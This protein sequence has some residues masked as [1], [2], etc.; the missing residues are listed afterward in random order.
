MQPQHAWVALIQFNVPSGDTQLTYFCRAKFFICVEW[1]WLYSAKG[2]QEI[3]DI[4]TLRSWKT[5]KRA[6]SSEVNQKWRNCHRWHVVNIYCAFPGFRG[7]WMT[8]CHLEN[9]LATHLPA[10]SPATWQGKITV[11]IAIERNLTRH[12]SLPSHA[13]HS[14]PPPTLFL[15]YRLC[16]F[17]SKCRVSLFSKG[18]EGEAVGWR[19][20]VQKQKPC[21][22]SHVSKTSGRDGAGWWDTRR[23]LMAYIQ[24]RRRVWTPAPRPPPLLTYLCSPLQATCSPSPALTLVDGDIV[25]WQWGGGPK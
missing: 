16:C 11:Q 8:D 1:L 9:N 13:V 22:K 4:K 12:L 7:R 23:T 19:E 21:V 24:N 14:H 20:L 15:F 25:I 6:R 2:C 5:K 17:R 3:N 18:S 10:N